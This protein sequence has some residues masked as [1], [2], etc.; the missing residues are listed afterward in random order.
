VD[1]EPIPSDIH[2]LARRRKL[3]QVRIGCQRLVKETTSSQNANT[4]Q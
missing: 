3:A 1:V 4:E 2:E